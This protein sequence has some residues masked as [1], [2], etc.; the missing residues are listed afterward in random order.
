MKDRIL[1]Q[2]DNDKQAKEFY[3]WFLKYGFDSLMS[4]TKCD[5]SCIISNENPGALS[6]ESSYFIEIQ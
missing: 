6:D 1:I 4:K 5:I 2:L 3:N